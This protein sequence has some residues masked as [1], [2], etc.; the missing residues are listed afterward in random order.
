M[1]A[2][3]TVY[4]SGQIPLDPATMT[5]V[6]NGDFHT[7]ARQVFQTCRPSPKRQ[8]VRWTTSSNSTPT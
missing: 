4:M 6:G 7:E 8:A 2:G 1:R 5:V 3:G